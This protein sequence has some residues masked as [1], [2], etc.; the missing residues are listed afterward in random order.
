MKDIEPDIDPEEGIGYAEGPAVTKAYV[1]IPVGVETDR[2][3]QSDAG[4]DHANGQLQKSGR[5]I[6]A[7]LRDRIAFGQIGRPPCP[8]V[9]AERDAVSDSLTEIEPQ[10]Q[11]GEDESRAKHRPLNRQQRP[12]DAGV[13]ELPHPPPFLCIAGDDS[14]DDDE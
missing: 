6:D 5:K 9:L 1:G 11:K 2:E 13:V 14:Q 3:E 8:A 4:T 10:V 12:K 7:G